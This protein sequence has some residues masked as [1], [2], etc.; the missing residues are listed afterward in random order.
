MHKKCQER[1]R[2]QFKC[3]SGLAQGQHACA[4]VRLWTL[5]DGLNLLSRWGNSWGARRGASGAALAIPGGYRS[6]E[7]FYQSSYIH[8]CFNTVDLD[9]V[10]M[11]LRRES[12]SI[13]IVPLLLRELS[14]YPYILG[15]Y[16][17]IVPSCFE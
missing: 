8:C 11:L 16:S 6:V 15:S 10:M 1:I 9:V 12:K 13:I 4:S 5:L 2:P 7:P 14:T 3:L 17:T